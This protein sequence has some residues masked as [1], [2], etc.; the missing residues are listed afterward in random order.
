MRSAGLVSDSSRSGV[1]VVALA[2]AASTSYEMARR[3]AEGLAIPRSEKLAA[4]AEWLKVSPAL[5][6][7]GD[8]GG[9]A[10]IDEGLLGKCIEAVSS[11]EE[12]IG[13]KL[14]PEKKSRLIAILYRETARD[15]TP[16]I[17]VVSLMVRA[18][19]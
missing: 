10:D 1:D 18:I 13:A 9:A 17:E 8:D 2:D 3:Y 16:A 6:A 11:A 12:K 4:I 14:P 7:W 5:L 15:G 19:A